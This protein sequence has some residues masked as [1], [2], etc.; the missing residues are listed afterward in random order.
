MQKLLS[1]SIVMVLVVAGMFA[2]GCGGSDSEKEGTLPSLQ[3]GD[4]WV[5]KIT[6][7]SFEHT[8]TM[9]ITGEDT[10]EGRETYVIKG[11]FEP[12][13]EGVIGTFDQKVDKLTLNVL[14][15][16]MSG[17]SMGVPFIV[18]NSSVYEPDSTLYPLEVGKEVT[19][20]VTETITTKVLGEKETETETNLFTYKVESIEQITVPAGTFR[21]FKVVTYD[22][23]G[24]A[25]ETSWVSDAVKSYPLKQIDHE[26]E[27]TFEL[28]SYS[29]V[30]AD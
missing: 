15:L 1:A 19:S 13:V 7:D 23:L 3:V 6:S 27:D 4:T 25:V 8:M 11:S 16:Q 14:R 17:E 20:T 21:A 10:T 18:I 28:L 2:S 26:S 12:P 29:L 22:E 5:S 30:G 24:S 9:E